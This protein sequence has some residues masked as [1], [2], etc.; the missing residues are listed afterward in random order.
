VTTPN[1]RNPAPRPP[2]LRPLRRLRRLLASSALLTALS[3]SATGCGGEAT[4]DS[5]GAKGT[6]RV[7][8]IGSKAELTGPLGFLNSEKKLLPELGKLGFAKIEV[9]PFPNGP[10]LNQALVGGSLDVAT[11]GDTPA[12]V[13]RGSGL[14]TRLISVASV[15]LDA[16]IVVRKDGPRS[17]DD[18]RGKKVGVQTGSYIHRYLL[19]ALRDADVEPSEVPHIY[20]TDIQAPLERGDIAAAAVPQVNAEVFASKGFRIL[21]HLAEDHPDYAGTSVTVS[22]STFLESHPEFAGTWQRLQKTAVA[23]A[24]SHWDAYTDFAVSLSD[25]PPDVVRPT[26][27]EDQLPDAAYPER[28]LALLASTKKFL[29]REK[30]VKKDFSVAEWK[31]DAAG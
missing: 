26:I 9:F 5:D 12:L 17:L 7:G 3:L 10:D 2:A 28:G 11:Y 8:V 16:S 13:A 25:F 31:A 6:L 21:D 4:A 27:R 15:D 30:F 24:R 18:L 29:V 20:T 1:E 14:D 22:T 23:D 19:G